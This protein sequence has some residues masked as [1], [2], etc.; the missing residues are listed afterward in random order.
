MQFNS[1]EQLCINYTNE[2][3]HQTFINE[4][5]ETEKKVGAGSACALMV[6]PMLACAHGADTCAGA[7]AAA[8]PT[9]TSLLSCWSNTLQEMS[10]R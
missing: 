3:L 6:V 9:D 10:C 1:L 5:F 8:L 2:K 4:V 7:G